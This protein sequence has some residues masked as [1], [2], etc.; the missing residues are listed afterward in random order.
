MVFF[1]FE[2]FMLIVDLHPWWL[3]RD[4]R[5]RVILGL[6]DL[7]RSIHPWLRCRYLWCYWHFRGML[8]EFG[9]FGVGV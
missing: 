2:I 4:L 1:Y 9:H 6:L 5:R 8:K 7:C 3:F